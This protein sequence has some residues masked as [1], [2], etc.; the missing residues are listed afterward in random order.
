MAIR[1]D[2]TDCTVRVPAA[3]I[4]ADVGMPNGGGAYTRV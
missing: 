2:A 1:L 4:L 3:V